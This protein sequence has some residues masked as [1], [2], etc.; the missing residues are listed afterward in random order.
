MFRLITQPRLVD[1]EAIPH[2][3]LIRQDKNAVKYLLLDYNPSAPE[4]LDNIN[5][6]KTQRRGEIRYLPFVTTLESIVKNYE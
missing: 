1:K 2:G 6:L 5:I 3:Y 4:V